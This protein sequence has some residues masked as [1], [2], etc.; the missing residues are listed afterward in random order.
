MHK[1]CSG[2]SGSV[3]K[4]RYVGEPLVFPTAT[5][6]HALL[7]TP[8]VLAGHPGYAVVRRSIVIVPHG[9]GMRRRPGGKQPGRRYGPAP[10]DR[11]WRAVAGERVV[12]HQPFGTSAPT[13]VA[14]GAK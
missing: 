10:K 8:D 11:A 2:C 7:P 3:T 14:R 5:D 9:T 4:L 6:P 12:Y 13:D 1:N